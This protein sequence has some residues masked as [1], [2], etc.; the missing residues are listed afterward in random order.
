[1]IRKIILLSLLLMGGCA[2]DSGLVNT[3][4]W[5]SCETKSSCS[6]YIRKR[7]LS[8]WELPSNLAG[9]VQNARFELYLSESGTV[10]SM[11]KVASSGSDVFDNHAEVAINYAA[12]FL[13]LFRPDIRRFSKYRKMLVEFNSKTKDLTVKLI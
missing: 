10:E 8:K 4:G 1:M 3:N 13:E 12:P 11:S 6:T 2:T 5:V 9:V 7:I